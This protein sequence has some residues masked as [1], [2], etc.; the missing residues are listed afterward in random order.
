[1]R[2][3]NCDYLS[4][5]LYQSKQLKTF[6]QQLKLRNMSIESTRCFKGKASI[7]DLILTQQGPSF[8]KTVISPFTGSDHHMISTQY[9]P[10]GIKVP[11]LHKYVE[12]RLLKRMI[13]IE[14][15]HKCIN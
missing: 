11:A 9:Y 15:V 3:L 1:M 8:S 4:P 13:D 14:V 6:C 7:L 12:L 10:R 2:D 5:G